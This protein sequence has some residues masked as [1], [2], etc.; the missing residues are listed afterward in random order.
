MRRVISIMVNCCDRRSSRWPFGRQHIRGDARKYRIFAIQFSG[1]AKGL[2]GGGAPQHPVSS[3]MK[4][5]MC[6]KVEAYLSTALN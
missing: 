1:R 3:R 5:Y 2:T 4:L 6:N